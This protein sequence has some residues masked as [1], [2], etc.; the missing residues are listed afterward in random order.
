MRLTAS[1]KGFQGLP[2]FSFIARMLQRRAFHELVFCLL[3][4]QLYFFRIFADL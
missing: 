1:C 2:T 4:L 3:S